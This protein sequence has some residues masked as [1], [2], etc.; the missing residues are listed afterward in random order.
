MP[1]LIDPYHRIID[2]LRISITDRCNLRCSYCMP[3]TGASLHPKSEILTYEEILKVAQ[4]CLSLGINKFRL[5]GGEP[6][7]RQGLEELVNNLSQLMGIQDLSLTTNGILFPQ[8]GKKLAD[9]GLQ[10]VNI[11][12]DTLNPAKFHKLT[13]GGD[14]TQVMEAIRLALQLNLHPVKINVVMI[15]GFNDD[16]LDD[17]IHWVSGQPLIL[18]FIEF[19]PNSSTLDEAWG[20]EKV[21]TA[22]EIRERCLS[23]R[24][25]EPMENPVHGFGPAE[26]WNIPETQ[27]RVGFINPISSLHFC[28]RCRRIRLSADGHLHLCLHHP[29]TVDLKTPLRKGARI[30]DVA[31]LIREGILHKPGEHQLREDFHQCFLGS[32]S[33]IGG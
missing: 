11:S 3:S 28:E 31:R 18:R 25:M 14:L 15:R 32:M 26:Y 24:E 12:L 6:L 5:T 17:F 2:Y 21:I 1:E 23:L 27:T 29:F 20:P 7:M 10:R 8:Q 22:D 30:E 4:A 19:M 16:E 33:Q 9:S 13:R